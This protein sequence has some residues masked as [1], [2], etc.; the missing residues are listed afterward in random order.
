MGTTPSRYDDLS[1]NIYLEKFCGKKSILPNDPFW[2]TFLSYNMRPPVTRNDQIEL[3]SRLDSSCQ[4]LLANNISTGNFGSLIQVALMRASNLLAPMQNQKI[5][6][7][8]QT[9]NALFAVRCILKYLIETVGEEEMIKHIEAPQLPV[10]TQSNASYRLKDLFEAL[11]DIITDVPLCEFTYVVHLEAIN[12]LLVLLS[13]QLFSQTAAEYSC[14][15]RIAMHSHSSEHAPAMV[16]TLLH[17]FV[18]QEHAPPGLLTQQPGGSIV[19]SIAA[20]LWN[21]ITMGMGSSLKNVQVTSNGTSEEEERKRDTETPLASQSLLLLLVLT[22]HCTATQNPYRNALF[23]FVDM[24]EDYSTMQGKSAFRFNINKLYNTICKIP[25]TDEV[26][27]LLYMLLHRNSSVKQDIMRRSDI[28]L[29]VTPILQILYHAPNNTSHHIYM[30]L[31]ILLILSEDETFNKRIHEIMLKG[32]NWYTERSISEISLGGLLILVV[33]RTIQY[34]MFKMRDKYLHTNCLAALANMSAQFTSLHPYVSQRLL[35]LFE[36]LAKKH[37]RLETKIRTQPSVSS[38]NTTITINGTT[39]NTDL[40]Q[41]LTILEEVLR[42]VLEIINSCLTHR[43]AHNP[44]LIYTLLYKKD[45]FQPFRMHSAFQDIVQNI[46]SVINFFSYKLE[47]KDQSQ[48]GV[49]QVLTTIQQGTSEWPRDRLRKFPE[50][51]FKY[52]EEEQPEEFFIPYVW[53]VVCQS[54]LLHWNAENIKL[55]SPHSGEQ[56]TIIVC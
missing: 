14:I 7:A 45:I 21:V 37:A 51:K 42:M 33:I 29:L 26:T 50:L 47:Q 44:N 18:Q 43:L 13:V 2:N 36:T 12:C 35:S 4:Q 39:A 31:I 49:S 27:L 25:N 5:I 8:W 28:Q 54:A 34:N 41:D 15:Y 11:V 16:C 38:D 22:N 9:Y 30:S 46:D 23:T 1:K 20:G 10:P 53:S 32:V 19:F 48:L 52:V 3:D 40:I 17:N 6:S 55:F 56:T 24:Q